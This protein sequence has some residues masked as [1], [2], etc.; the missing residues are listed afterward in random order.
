MFLECKQ[1]FDIPGEK[2]EFDYSLDL[3]EV[4]LFSSKPFQSPV[5]VRGIAENRAQI[6]SLK[7]DCSFV[8]NLACDRC[9]ADLERKFEEHFSHVLVRELSSEEDDGGDYIVVEEDSLD[10]DELILSDIL[11]CLPTK[12]L[13]EEDC[14]GLCPS[15][16]KNLNFDSCECQKKQVDPRLAKLSE[17]LK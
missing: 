7:V 15:C 4:E 10:L 13:C 12:F 6:V 9:L 17:L 8:M 16:G 11:L 3:S 14:K 1:L 2:K 5:S